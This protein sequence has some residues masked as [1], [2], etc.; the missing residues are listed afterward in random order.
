M[1]TLNLEDKVQFKKFEVKDDYIIITLVDNNCIR[2]HKSE[3]PFL[4]M[5]SRRKISKYEI[6]GEG[7]GVHFPLLDE[8]LSAAYLI[9]LEKYKNL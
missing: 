1:N 7:E 6:M 3:I 2:R 8:D 9:Y 5:A 4:K